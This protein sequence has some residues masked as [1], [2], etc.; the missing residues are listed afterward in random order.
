MEVHV[1]DD[2]TALIRF[3]ARVTITGLRSEHIQFALSHLLDELDPHIRAH[4]ADEHDVVLLGVP[5]RPVLFRQARHV[6]EWNVARINGVLF[7]AFDVG[8]I[9]VPDFAAPQQLKVHRREV[10]IPNL[11]E[12][13][14][15][16]VV[17][18]AHESLLGADVPADDYLPLVLQ[19]SDTGPALPDMVGLQAQK[20]QPIVNHGCDFLELMGLHRIADFKRPHPI[21]HYC[22]AR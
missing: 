12:V 6:A 16:G 22:T 14:D 20:L 9:V 7:Q 3:R 19:V 21:T 4:R 10:K 11:L 18:D 5:L 13:V 1:E 17:G 8:V 15:D 2:F